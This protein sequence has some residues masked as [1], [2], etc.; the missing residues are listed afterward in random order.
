MNRRHCLLVGLV[1]L[2]MGTASLPVSEAAKDTRRKIITTITKDGIPIEN[3]TVE[4]WLNNRRILTKHTNNYGQYTFGNL[5]F[6]SYEVR[7]SA[8]INRITYRGSLS[9]SVTGTHL[10]LFPIALQR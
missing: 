1:L 7:A 9:R 4:L 10:Y 3:A 8:T 2:T 5:D 6:G